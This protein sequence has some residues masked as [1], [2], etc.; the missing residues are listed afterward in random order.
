MP[1][2]DHR[3]LGGT[4]WWGC[5]PQRSAPA[6][7]ALSQAHSACIWASWAA[8]PQAWAPARAAFAPQTPPSDR[9]RRRSHSRWTSSSVAS[10]VLPV[11]AAHPA[12]P[13]QPRGPNNRPRW[14]S[15]RPAAPARR[16]RR[17]PGRRP[18]RR[19]R[20]R[21]RRASPPAP[22]GSPG[23][24]CASWRRWPRGWPRAPSA[25]AARA[26]LGE[27]RLEGVDARPTASR[28]S[29]EGAGWRCLA[30]PSRR[31]PPSARPRC[32]RRWLWRAR[33]DPQLGGRELGA[34]SPCRSAGSTARDAGHG[35]LHPRP[36]G[37][38]PREVRRRGENQPAPRPGSPPSACGGGGGRKRRRAPGPTGCARR[39][40]RRPRPRGGRRARA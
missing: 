21:R 7:L 24:A 38:L 1:C 40:G 11:V 16:S 8:L 37:P 17:R 12:H 31:S 22:P 9:P 32:R 26:H 3:E 14:R 27:A 33:R 13:A 18:R 19:G 28:S 4:W 6:A 2:S 20:R 29:Q 10:W 39:R 5:A 30:P 35:L 34:A 25:L 36:Q 23:A 15:R